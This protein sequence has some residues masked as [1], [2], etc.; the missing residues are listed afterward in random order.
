MDLCFIYS[1]VI[2]FITFFASCIQID[3][4]FL[5]QSIV[6]SQVCKKQANSLYFHHQFFVKSKFKIS[7]TKI[8]IFSFCHFSL[9]CFIVIIFSF[10]F[11]AISK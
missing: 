7:S 8:S 9:S 4:I 10:I 6:I 1:K 5:I 3:F 2:S 11:L